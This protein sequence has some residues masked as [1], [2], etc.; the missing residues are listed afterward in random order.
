ME[1]RTIRVRFAPSPTGFLHLGG[2]RTAL[3]NWL[4]ARHEGGK[5]LLRIEDTDR[6]RHSE[7]AVEVILEGLRW[8]G[9]DWDGPAIHQA[10]RLAL[11]R[12]A[13]E[14]MLQKALAYRCYCTPEQLEAMRKEQ[15][16]RGESVGYDGRCRH[17]TEFPEGQP[18]CLRFRVPEGD[19]IEFEDLVYGKITVDRKELDDLVILK[20]DGFP[21]YNFANVIDDSE[22]KIT[23]VIRGEDHINNTPRQ[24]AI[25][26]ALQLEPP[27]FAH[28]PMIV[29]ENRKK[30][31]KRHS[32]ANVL[33]YREEGVLPEAL[34]NYI[35][36][37]GWGY[38]D[39]EFFTREELIE[40]FTLDRVNKA[41]CA[42]DPEKFQW[43]CGKHMEAASSER[44]G[45]LWLERLVEQGVIGPERRD[46]LLGTAWLDKAVAT[47][48]VRAK[49][50]AEM[51]AAGRF[52]FVLPD[53][54]D[55]KGV[56]KFL[57]PGVLPALE[58]LCS[59]LR[60]L[61]EPLAEAALEEQFKL[62]LEK[63]DLKLLKLAQPVRIFLTGG[64]AS[65]GIFEV[66]SLLGK[67]ETLRRIENGLE[68]MK[69]RPAE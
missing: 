11:Y 8:L 51:A 62:V 52:Y 6:S 55:E 28:L 42:I 58:E 9:L 3:Y 40:K 68:F 37:L 53:R 32:A 34:L 38:G 7:E 63:H 57:K 27:R 23:H 20:T 46:A 12:Q 33:A 56:H 19:P 67:E 49:T 31:S 4:F 24:I 64:T 65:P 35:A 1:A 21:S 10:E 61:E 45:R 15:Q 16:A 39:Q 25:Y 41:A 30:L 50:I 66:I 36:K 59:A 54:Y 26:Q 5:F 29:D 18:Y 14:A 43:L 47:L 17:R 48:K 60:P 44:L 22:M 69:T 2:V 13:A